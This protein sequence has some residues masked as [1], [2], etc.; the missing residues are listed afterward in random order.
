MGNGE[1]N[2]S[3]FLLNG[4]VGVLVLA[5][6]TLL[7]VC[8]RLFATRIRYSAISE[9]VAEKKKMVIKKRV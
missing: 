4:G 8:N 1:H 6:I 9:S 3:G 2:S 5:S 7:S